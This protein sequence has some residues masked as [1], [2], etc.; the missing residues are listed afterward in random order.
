MRETLLAH[1]ERF[2]GRERHAWVLRWHHRVE[3]PSRTRHRWLLAGSGAAG[4]AADFW[5]HLA[6]WLTLRRSA[7]EKPARALAA[8]GLAILAQR[9]GDDAVRHFLT[10]MYARA[11]PHDFR[12]WFSEQY[13]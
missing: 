3:A 8:T 7:G 9:H 11:E 12:G 10:A 6:T 5:R 13:N 1:T 4:D 2:A